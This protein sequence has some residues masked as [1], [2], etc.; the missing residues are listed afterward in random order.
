[1]DVGDGDDEDN[2][3]VLHVSSQYRSPLSFLF[4]FLFFPFLLC[5]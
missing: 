2:G 4:F 5:E 3:E 1:M